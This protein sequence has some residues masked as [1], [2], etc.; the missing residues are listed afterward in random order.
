M[1]GLPIPNVYL[2]L[3][4][5]GDHNHAIETDYLNKITTDLHRDIQ[6]AL[7]QGKPMVG[8]LSQYT[9]CV[10]ASCK[11][12]HSVTFTVNDRSASL[13]TQ[14]KREMHQEKESIDHSQMPLSNYFTFSG[15]ILALCL[16]GVR[17]NVHLTTHLIT[18]IQHNALV[19]AG[20]MGSTDTL[21]MAGMALSCEKNSGLYTHNVAALEAAITKIK[22]KLETTKP[23]FHIGN[24]FS[25]PIAIMALV[26]M[27][28]QK[29]LTSTML[30]LRAEAQSGTYYNPMA[31]SY[32]LMGLQR[33][34]YQDVKNVNCQNEQN[35]LVLEPAVEVELEV[36]PNQKATVVVEVVKS[37][38]QIH[39]YTTHV[40][41]GTSLLTALELIRAKNAGFT[42]EVEPSQWGPY[43][44]NVNGEHARQSDRRAWYL[45]LDGVPLSEGITDFKIIGPHVITIKNTTY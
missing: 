20:V 9:M 4:L 22:D 3:R 13:I 39:I 30:K 11:N 18:V 25:T 24:K 12:M 26:A 28:S 36:V 16:A 45:L 2:A 38:G 5:S 44:S 15:G 7:S 19:D 23:D 8:L 6:H 35:N 33:K 41:K 34:T 42:F 32:A 1:Q 10:L 14:L 29:D 17:V 37:N 40:S 27:G 43:L 21:A 31:L